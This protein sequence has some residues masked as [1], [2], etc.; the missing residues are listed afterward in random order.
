MATVRRKLTGYYNY[1]GITDNSLAVEKF[2]NRSINI[3]FKWLNRRSQ[4]M[5]FT[6]EEFNKLLKEYK[7]PKPT[8]KVNIYELVKQQFEE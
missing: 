4:R 2:Y 5:S 1:F 8:T 7:I 3:L 6:R